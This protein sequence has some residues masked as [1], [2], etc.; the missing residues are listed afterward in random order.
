[1]FPTLQQDHLFEPW[2]NFKNPLVRQLAF[3]LASPNILSAYP[4]QFDVQ[5][6]FQFHTE[7]VWTQYFHLYQTR[8]DYLDQHP[9]ELEN[10]LNQLSS[11]YLFA[12]NIQLDGKNK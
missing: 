2:L 6:A 8:L 10:F 5:Q 7:S 3:S 4:E 9:T 1:M 11:K 12:E